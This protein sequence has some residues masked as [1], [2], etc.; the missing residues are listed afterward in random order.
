MDFYNSV[1]FSLQFKPVNHNENPCVKEFDISVSGEFQEVDA[2]ILPAPTLYYNQGRS[3]EVRRGVWQ[4]GGVKFNKPC[5][6]LS[7]DNIWTILKLD[8][9]IHMDSVYDFANTLS[10]EGKK[11]HISKTSEILILSNVKC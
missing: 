1:L 3:T 7:K 10:R 4:L 5:T 11:C 6:L 8:S 2:R 9:Q